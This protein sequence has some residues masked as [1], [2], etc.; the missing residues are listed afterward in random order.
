MEKMGFRW[1]GEKDDPITLSQIRQIPGTTQVVGALYDVPVGDV[2]PRE[3]IKNL[4]NQVEDAGLKLEVIES[5]NIHDD[6][7]AGK[8]GR[9]K[10]FENYQQTIRN[11]A[12]FGIKV[13]CYNFM[14]I[15][16]WMR[17]DLKYQ[18]ADGSNVMRFQSAGLEKSPEQII[19]DVQNGSNGYSLP[20]WEPERLTT[21][22]GLF[23]EYAG[24]SDNQLRDN[25]QYFLQAIIPVCEECDVKM[26]I[27][28]DDPPRPL[29][30][31]PR[32]YKNI[33]DMRQIEAMVDS[34]Y[35]GFTICTGSLGENPS[36]DIP[37]IIRE[38]VSRNRVP[39]VHA[40]NI[41]FDNEQ[42]DFHET[43]HLSDEG[44]LDMY[45]IMKA[46]HDTH[47]DGYIRPD[48]GRNIWGET[49]RPGYGLYDRA[50]GIAYLNG[51]WEALEK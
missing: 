39:F 21:V 43:A 5:V 19:D 8:D 1:F 20:G 47:F 15:F 51:L 49:G 22:K 33:D 11:L 23:K 45:E 42:G 44:S 24:I 14:P 7:K 26:A 10:Y 4:K 13:I 36:N 9:D 17:T 30:G 3:K 18:L 46:L 29:F 38:F 27:H 40:R 31:L 32:I 37:A 34:P 25:L 28:P 35:N 48:H 6:I 16:D 41:K 12:S 50:L 2:W